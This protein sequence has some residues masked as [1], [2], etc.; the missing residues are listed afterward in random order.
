MAL[1]EREREARR[2]CCFRW[3]TGALPSLLPNIPDDL[4]WQHC[5]H[6]NRPKLSDY[7]HG[8][9]SESVRSL[10]TAVKVWSLLLAFYTF[11]KTETC[12]TKEIYTKR[13]P[14][15]LSQ[16]LDVDRSSSILHEPH[17]VM[18]QQHFLNSAVFCLWSSHFEI[19]NS[20]ETNDNTWLTPPVVFWIQ[21]DT[22]N[23]F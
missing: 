21:G 4:I 2:R 10:S 15:R 12:F 6:G 8:C 17:P 16:K 5:C 19:E 22:R 1:R 11:C 3:D 14:P 9:Q 20:K 13:S 23:H 7:C 18:A